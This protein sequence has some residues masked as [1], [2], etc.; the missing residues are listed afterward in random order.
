MSRF[1]KGVGIFLVIVFIMIVGNAGVLTKST[2]ENG[3]SPK[4]E[5][6]SYDVEYGEYG[7]PIVVGVVKNNTDETYSYAQV[8]VNIYERNGPQI[9]STIA[10]I[11]NLDAGGEWKFE[12]RVTQDPPPN[13][14]E[15]K[16]KD[17]SGY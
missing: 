6:L 7:S 2:S 17:V 16:I 8:E 5:L 10:N 14:F 13:G 11:S 9:G 15:Y 12:A 1:A 3:S 4:L